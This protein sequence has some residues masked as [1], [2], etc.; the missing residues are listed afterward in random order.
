MKRYGLVFVV[1]MSAALASC[2]TRRE[3]APA[4]EP[5]PPIVIRETPRP[6][7]PPPIANWQ[8]APLAPGDW[9]HGQEGG[10]SIAR[11]GPPGAPS[12][13]LRCEPGR[14]V[15]LTR[16]DAAAATALTVRTSSTARTLVARGSMALLPASDPLLDAIVFSR[17]RFAVETTG[18]GT[19]VV[20]AWPEAARVIEDCRG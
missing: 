8:D 7:P 9:T 16:T 1:A 13:V 6:V 14:Q 19:L 17:G 18:H 4:P 20:P 11:F 12:F 3:P 5:S 15:S 2:A 10:I